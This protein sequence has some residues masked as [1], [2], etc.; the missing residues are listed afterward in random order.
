MIKQLDGRSTLHPKAH[1]RKA[2]MSAQFIFFSR[3]GKKS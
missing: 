1:Q 3:L 2:S